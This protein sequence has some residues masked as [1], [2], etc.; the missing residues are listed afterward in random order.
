MFTRAGLWAVIGGWVL[1][2]PC[3]AQGDP[4]VARENAQL[5]R[6]VETLEKQV[7]QLQTTVQDQTS[8]PPA[9]SAAAA[10]LEPGKK[11][12]WSTLDVQFYGY[13][14]LDAA[15]DSS[16][17][18]PGD[19][20]LYTES[21]HEG[22]DEFNLTARQT[23][24]GV[25]IKGPETGNMKT[26]G[27]V[28][29][30]FYGGAGAENKPNILVRHA[31]MT[32]DW[33]DSQFSVI[34][35]Q[36]S[37][38]FSPLLPNTLN[39]TVLWDAGNIG[40][41]HPQVRL[42]KQ[43]RVGDD[44][45][46]EVAGAISRTIGDVETLTFTPGASSGFPT[47]QSRVGLTFPWFGFKPTTAGVS[48]HWGREQYSS[49]EKIDSWSLNLDVLQPICPVVTVKGEA[50]V[51]ENLDDYFGGIGQGVRT[52]GGRM[53]G[54]GDKGGWFAVTLGPWDPWTFNVGAGIDDVDNEDVNTNDRTCNQSLFANALYAVNRNA[55]IGV[56]LSQWR[57]G[58]KNTG[59]VDDTRIQASFIYKF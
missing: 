49:D 46:L 55:D 48:G 52:V 20:V 16:G 7:Q 28:E 47:L 23:R 33:P 57:T 35:G 31:Y 32:F 19:Y 13:I 39:Y 25:K 2:A 5:R 34:A 21:G 38:L 10:G 44:T 51:G 42:T 37:D 58:Y 3:L 4:N 56:E 53:H 54:I 9:P 43:F 36:T 24:L 27:V 41:R 22:D 29:G 12:F 1:S 50:Y 40:Y 11:P 45:T 6:R 59:A 18:Y 15:W 8:A 14:K 30:D 17:V 26:S